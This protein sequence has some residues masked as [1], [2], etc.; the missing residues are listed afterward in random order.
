MIISIDTMVPNMASLTDALTHRGRAMHIC[1]SKLTI[2]ASDNGLSPG[3][4]QAIIWNNAVNWI[5]RNKLQWNFDE[6]SDIFFQENALES[7][8]RKM[9]AILSQPQ[10]VNISVQNVKIHNVLIF[11]V[12]LQPGTH[13][14]HHIWN[15][16]E[17]FV[18]HFYQSTQRTTTWV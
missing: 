10:C 16:V 9:A 11:F 6:N 8:V 2:I 4:C 13:C 5:L 15:N 3:Q 1:V 12:N 18:Y 14:C 7:V 17:H